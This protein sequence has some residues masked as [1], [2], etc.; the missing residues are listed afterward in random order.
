VLLSD[1]QSYQV[2]DDRHTWNLLSGEQVNLQWYE[3]SWSFGNALKWIADQS[4]ER[5]AQ[6]AG[7]RPTGEVWITIY[8][9]MPELKEVDIHIYEWAGGIA[10]PVYN[11]TIIA[12]GTDELDWAESVIPHELAHLLT[13]SVVYNCRGMWLPTW[14]SEGLAE[15]AEGETYPS[16]AVLVDEALEDDE[17]P[18]LRTLE[19]GF[20][21]DSTEASLSYGHSGMVV[22]Y[23]IEQF[24][25]EK[26][27]SLLE[28]IKSGKKIDKA[29]EAV[30]GMNTDGIEAEW[31]I[32]L[33]FKAQPT[34]A[35][36]D[37][38]RTAVPTIAL[39]TS[40]VRPT[41]TP[42]SKPSD[43]PTI[44][45]PTDTPRPPPSTTPAIV[46][47]SNVQNPNEPDVD[48]PTSRPIFLVILPA[49]GL[50]LITGGIVFFT[51]MR[52]GREP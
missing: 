32:S 34:L 12:I 39:W 48:Q 23:M 30:Y 47:V 9:T 19:S 22:T 51:K 42:T 52:K 5:L 38:N 44:A 18:P 16:Y 10:Y 15:F 2:T 20:S 41:E 40:V 13:D 4:L 29:L 36:T 43:T 8:P 6:D 50:I 46:A 49:I 21:S 14:L 3:G 35:P 28:E 24:G 31:R 37:A 27:A 11:S 25:A 45:V 17:L 33:G 7:V 1:E 26:I